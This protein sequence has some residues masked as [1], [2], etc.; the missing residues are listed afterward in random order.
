MGDP[1]LSKNV[2]AKNFI[3][4]GYHGSHTPGGQ[5]DHIRSEVWA[6]WAPQNQGAAAASLLEE[7]FKV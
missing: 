5:M 7:R 1:R 2:V 6:V 4:M 3:G